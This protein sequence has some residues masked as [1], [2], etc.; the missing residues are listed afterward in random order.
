MKGGIAAID[1]ILLLLCARAASP[2]HFRPP[3]EASELAPLEA[4]LEV[5]AAVG[6]PAIGGIF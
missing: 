4:P 3:E 5:P 6:V 1:M 2:Q